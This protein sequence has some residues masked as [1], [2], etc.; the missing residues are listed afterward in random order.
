MRVSKASRRNKGSTFA[1]WELG[2]G[3]LASAGSDPSF[4]RFG[5]DLIHTTI[6]EAD[7]I[8]R[9]AAIGTGVPVI[10]SLVNTPYEPI[11]LQDPNVTPVALWRRSRRSTVRRPGG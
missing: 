5:P 3:D 1:S 6:F 2:A 10:T 11:R 4:E 8:G 9:I 7:V